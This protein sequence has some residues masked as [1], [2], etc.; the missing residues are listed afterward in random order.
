VLDHRI[1]PKRKQCMHG[2]V[3]KRDG[4]QLMKA[5]LAA[6]VTAIGDSSFK[7]DGSSVNNYSTDITAAIACNVVESQSCLNIDIFS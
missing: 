2:C 3:V 6:C 1:A 4:A 7:A 5:L